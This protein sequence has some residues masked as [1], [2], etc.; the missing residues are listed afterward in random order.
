MQQIA[1]VLSSYLLTSAAINS[2]VGR[3]SDVYGRRLVY[4]SAVVVFFVGSLLCGLSTSI[5][6]LIL[7]RGVQGVGG[8]GIMGLTQTIVGKSIAFY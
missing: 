1:W 8:G 6:W 7:A 2:L 4:L 5:W 3:F